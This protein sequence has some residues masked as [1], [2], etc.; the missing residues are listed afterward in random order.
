VLPSDHDMAPLKDVH[1]LRTTKTA[2][3]CQVGC[4][5]V[6]G[7]NQWAREEWRPVVNKDVAVMNR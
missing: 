3:A 4:D 1:H 6:K 5:R 2:V 7:K